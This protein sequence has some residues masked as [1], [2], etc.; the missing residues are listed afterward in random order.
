MKE[1]CL[2]DVCPVEDRVLHVHSNFNSGKKKNSKELNVRS[3]HDY[4]RIDYMQRDILH[5]MGLEMDDSLHHMDKGK[6]EGSGTT[7][8]NFG[9][10]YINDLA[11]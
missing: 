10:Y 4:K 11:S 6:A 1:V 7:R 3:R 2:G 5:S 8:M 9:R